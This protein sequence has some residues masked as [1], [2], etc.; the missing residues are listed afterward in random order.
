MIIKILLL[1]KSANQRR[2]FANMKYMSY[3]FFLIAI[4]IFIVDLYNVIYLKEVLPFINNDW[5][6]T[7]V[8]ISLVIAITIYKIS[9][10]K[11]EKP[12]KE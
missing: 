12:D 6:S 3:L 5:K 9:N 10:A 7:T 2:D 8:L 11:I 1:R 4:I